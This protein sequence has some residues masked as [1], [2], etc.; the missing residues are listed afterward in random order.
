[1]LLAHKVAK[2]NFY[3]CLNLFIFQL[4][5]IIWSN[6]AP[7]TT[8]S[9]GSLA[10]WHILSSVEITSF[11]LNFFECQPP[12][13]NCLSNVQIRSTD[14]RKSLNLTKCWILPLGTLHYI[15]FHFLHLCA[16]VQYDNKIVLKLFMKIWR[17]IVQC[18]LYKYDVL[19]CVNFSDAVVFIL[20][21][22]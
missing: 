3:L 6:S 14:T 5:K 12:R 22:Q 13:S 15:F 18:P 2:G 21:G 10:R 17:F 9:L 16:T 20:I 19:F 4:P 1:M 7:V 11:E 8:W